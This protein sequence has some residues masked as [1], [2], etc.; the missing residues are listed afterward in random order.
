MEIPKV[1]E[2]SPLKSERDSGSCC[3]YSG[4][5]LRYSS[6]LL[7]VSHGI[8]TDSLHL[9]LRVR[10]P[11]CRERSVAIGGA[12]FLHRTVFHVGNSNSPLSALCQILN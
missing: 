8:T 12:L 1:C 9:I 10:V 2:S 3:P 5:A 11:K 4:D 6:K 7:L